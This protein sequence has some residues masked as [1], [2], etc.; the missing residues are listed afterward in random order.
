MALMQG[1]M[2]ANPVIS[3][4][5]SLQSVD[6]AICDEVDVLEQLGARV[7]KL[8]I[9]HRSIVDDLEMRRPGSSLEYGWTVVDATRQCLLP[10][11]GRFVLLQQSD[12]LVPRAA[13]LITPR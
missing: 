12:C 11:S 7:L 9:V 10:Q 13:S 4:E 3:G 8:H 5:S 6:K 1:L 2:Q